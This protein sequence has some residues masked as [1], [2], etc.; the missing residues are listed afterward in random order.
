MVMN[1]ELLDSVFQVLVIKVKQHEHMERDITV[2]PTIVDVHEGNKQITSV[3]VVIPANRFTCKK[4]LA[5][6]C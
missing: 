2:F 6:Q 3:C 5:T 4:I 1:N